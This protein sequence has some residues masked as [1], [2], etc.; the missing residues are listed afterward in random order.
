MGALPGG[1]GGPAYIPMKR[2]LHQTYMPSQAI[3]SSDRLK[4]AYWQSDHLAGVRDS[5]LCYWVCLLSATTYI[6]TVDG[7]I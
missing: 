2:K 7:A 3:P 5:L 4:L 6:V 1:A